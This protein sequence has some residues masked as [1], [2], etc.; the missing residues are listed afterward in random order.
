VEAQHNAEAYPIFRRDIA[1]L[2]QYFDR[3][4]PTTDPDALA[5][6]MWQRHRLPL[7]RDWERLALEVLPEPAEDEE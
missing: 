6:T 5:A 7:P 1:R 2:C 3:Y 4:G